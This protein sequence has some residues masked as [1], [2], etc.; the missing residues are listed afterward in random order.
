MIKPQERRRKA[1]HIIAWCVVLAL[2]LYFDYFSY[3]VVIVAGLFLILFILDILRLYFHVQLPF[4]SLLRKNEQKHF[5]TPTRTLLGLL[6][7]A[8]LFDKQLVVASF[9]MMIFGDVV[10]PLAGQYG[11][12]WFSFN[13]KKN[14]EGAI[15]EFVVDVI[16]GIIVVKTFST[17]MVMAL[18]ATV[19]ETYNLHWDDNLM[20]TPVASFAGT[21]AQVIFSG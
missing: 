3:G 1:F 14:L 19:V 18:A 2:Y 6:I 8:L 20:I 15:A 4:L 9:M 16:I 10:A 13:K 21:L 12:H 11:R 5:F 17:A 7:A